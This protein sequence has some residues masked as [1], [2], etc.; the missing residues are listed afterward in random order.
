MSK[1]DDV[2]PSADK[3]ITI[4]GDFNGVML[5]DSLSNCLEDYVKITPPISIQ[6]SQVCVNVI[7]LNVM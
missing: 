6:L 5:C 1:N 4:M 3:V 2:C 7:V